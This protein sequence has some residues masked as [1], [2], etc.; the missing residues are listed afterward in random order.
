MQLVTALYIFDGERLFFALIS[1]KLHCHKI[2]L[3]FFSAFFCRR[4]FVSILYFVR[5]LLLSL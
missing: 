4:S 3:S 5:L 2:K 1:K